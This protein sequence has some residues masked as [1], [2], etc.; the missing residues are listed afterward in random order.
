MRVAIF[1]ETFLPKTDGI[2]RVVCLLVDHLKRRGLDV[3]I[4]APK[5]GDGSVR[6]YQGFPVVTVSGVTFP[7]Y[8]ELKLAPPGYFTYREIADFK[9]DI[10]H[11]IHPIMIGIPGMMMAKY[12]GIPTLTSFHLDL[13][14]LAG[15]FNIGFMQ[16]VTDYLTRLVFNW[17]DYSLAPSKQIQREMLALGIKEVG[18]WGRGVDAGRFNPR[19]R[20][21][22]M[23]HFLSDGHPQETLLIYVGRLSN[24][25]Q[26]DKLKAVLEQVPG[27]R[28][29]LVGDGPARADLEKHFDGLPVKFTGYLS[30]E[31]LS[32]AY[33]SADIF[34]FPSALE[35]F[36]LV[37]TEAMAA[38]LPVVASR[39][40]GIPDVVQIGKTGYT[41]DVGDVAG[42]VEGVRRIIADP[43]RQAQMGRDARAFAETQSW[44]V[45]MDEVIAHY[46]R[47][48][49]L[50]RLSEQIG[51]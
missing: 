35:T 9:P 32:Q 51:A 13:A 42:L 29:A 49:H 21:A 33:A 45:M 38:G 48:I 7:L 41:F 17:A 34:A 28:L 11:F 39:V 26:V 4:V 5:L 25:K 20:D 24:E 44:E 22:A 14:R 30:G 23:R 3:M 47:L 31:A 1:T 46:A 2:V 40:G 8:P 50:Y 15:H 16:P 37:V 43:V 19:Y 12:L 10:A 18:L 27:T 36:G 6:E